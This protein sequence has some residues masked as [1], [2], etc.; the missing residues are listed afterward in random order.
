MS[1]GNLAP[2]VMFVY[3]RVDHTRRTVEALAA[4]RMADQSDL[5]VYCD[6]PKGEDEREKV[7]AVRDFVHTISGFKTVKVIENEK[8]LG[9]AKSVVAGVSETVERS[10]RVIVMEDDMITA[11]GFLSFMNGALEKYEYEDMVKCVSGYAYTD[12]LNFTENAYFLHTVSS[13]GW[14]TWARAWPGSHLRDSEQV[15]KLLNDPQDRH[16]FD[17]LGGMNFSG[18]LESTENGKCDSWAVYFNAHVF[19]RQGLVLYPEKSLLINIGQDGSGTHGDD[20]GR[21][22][23]NL[24]HEWAC[25]NWPEP[26]WNEELFRRFCAKIK[27]KGRWMQIWLRLLKGRAS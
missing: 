27:P 6:G 22:D 23:E 25:E 17:C 15:Q 20:I 24:D 9:L 4:N 10:G 13:W 3:K 18:M 8:N 21:K 12:D 11:K 5:V 7:Q 2:I 1:N 26:R 14:G 19:Q 16:R